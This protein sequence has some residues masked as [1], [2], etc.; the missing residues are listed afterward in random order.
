M[1][2]RAVATLLLCIVLSM[3]LAGCGDP[4]VDASSDE[5][6]EKSLEKVRLSLPPEEQKQFEDAVASLAMSDFDL[7][8][9]ASGDAAGR[10]RRGFKA[11][12]HGKTAAEIIEAA[13]IVDAERKAEAEKARALREAEE[14]ERKAEA[15]KARALREAEEA[16]RKAEAE[17]ARALREAEEAERKA[18]KKAEEERVSEL[19][20]RLDVVDAKYTFEKGWSDGSHVISVTLRNGLDV[21]V[22]GFTAT[23]TIS[24]PDRQVPWVKDKIFGEDVAGGIEPG[25]TR[26]F[27][28]KY[29][30]SAWAG[31]PRERADAVLSVRIIRIELADGSSIPMAAKG[32]WP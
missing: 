12:L 1:P 21:A 28:L 3:C 18:A 4:R 16:E 29:Y 32:F 8:S 23:G 22:A 31:A 17:K 11:N 27:T 15:E 20:R 24:T 30:E 2:D 19:L 25:E 7:R 9:F 14:A 5:A 13:A 6:L 26:S 10:L